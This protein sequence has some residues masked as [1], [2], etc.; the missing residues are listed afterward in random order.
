MAEKYPK[1]RFDRVPENLQ[2]V[3][4]HRPAKSRGRGWIGL[5][6]ALL[7][8]VI[9]V[10]LGVLGLFVVNGNINVT[11]LGSGMNGT[12]SATA[13]VAPTPTASAPARSHTP[14]STPTPTLTA[15]VDPALNVTVLNGTPTRGL[16]TSVGKTLSSDGWRV[17]TV[18]NASR[19]DVTRT[20]VYYSDAANREAA[21]GVVKS[22]TGADA[23]AVLSRAFAGSGADLVVVI[24]SDYSAAG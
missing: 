18:G 22:L 4:A 14:R 5:L 11:S 13:S 2:R 1:D 23:T 24:G 16:A 3:G 20:V 17:G 10:G 8:V 21:L 12:P 15:T 6:W 19:G 7:A 9:L